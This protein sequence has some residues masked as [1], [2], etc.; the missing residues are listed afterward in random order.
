MT[1]VAGDIPYRHMYRSASGVVVRCSGDYVGTF[2][3]VSD[4]TQALARHLGV[5]KK[6][7]PLRKAMIKKAA[8]STSKNVYINGGMYE[9]RVGNKYFG[10]FT[11]QKQAVAALPKHKAQS[12]TRSKRESG[13]VT[14]KRFMV[15]KRIFKTF[16]PA[17]VVH[18]ATFRCSNPVFC[19]SPGPL[20]VAATLGKEASWR[21]AVLKAWSKTPAEKRLQMCLMAHGDAKN[22]QVQEATQAA[23]QA[24]VNACCAMVDV[25]IEE[26]QYW[27]KHV[28]RG[29]TH[30]SGWLP[31]M[32]RAKILSKTRAEE[33][34][35]GCLIFA[36]DAK[37]KIVP[38]NAS[39]HV[40]SLGLLAEMQQRLVSIKT[41]TSLNKWIAGLR[42][43]R[44]VAKTSASSEGYALMWCYRSTMLA[45]MHAS[46]VKNLHHGGKNTM[47]DV[48]HAF[49]DQCQW[50]KTFCAAG[51]VA[52]AKMSV[53][54]FLRQI[55]YQDSLQFLTMDLC[56]FGSVRA[57]APETIE[58]MERQIKK[59]RLE[60]DGAS[61]PAHPAVVVARAMADQEAP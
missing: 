28:N 13:A 27:S 17:D 34:A 38:F 16:R 29:V 3:K 58:S 24:L 42:S 39:I 14:R 59:I 11:S 35:E 54:K 37:Y 36:S 23:H 57:V 46:G 51:G 45:E 5:A 6:D 49:P 60:L 19:R 1:Q 26:R 41:P 10:R 18:M 25:K 22:K 15:L 9:A 8:V 55:N 20:G 50:V 43:F 40:R 31:L 30:H 21:G 12:K 7:L 2:G 4:A 61:R 47:R 52:P 56:I 33:E 44:E 53:A 48:V 32:L